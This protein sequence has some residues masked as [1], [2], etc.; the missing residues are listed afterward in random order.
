M[1]RRTGCDQWNSGDRYQT[2]FPSI[3]SFHRNPAAGMGGSF[4]ENLFLIRRSP[5]NACIHGKFFTFTKIIF[6][7]MKKILLF[8]LL[9]SVQQKS[10]AQ[11]TI[12][13]GDLP[14]AGDT[15]RVSNGQQ[16]SGMDATLT[17]ANYTWDY[18]QL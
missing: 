9:V 18:S 4:N 16:F 5:R 11:I 7:Y 13:S 6:P 14:A 17:G 1:G 12:V 2:G 8:L 10:N 15:F 3:S